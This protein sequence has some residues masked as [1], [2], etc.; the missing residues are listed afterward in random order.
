VAHQLRAGLLYVNQCMTGVNGP[1]GG[2][3]MSGIGREG[4][5]AGLMEYMQSKKVSINN[6]ANRPSGYARVSGAVT[7]QPEAAVAPAAKL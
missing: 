6:G 2:W 3:K 7:A 1:G 5:E 4:G